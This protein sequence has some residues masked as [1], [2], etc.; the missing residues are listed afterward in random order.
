M[1]DHYIVLIR[2]SQYTSNIHRIVPNST[3]AAVADQLRK[4]LKHTKTELRKVKQELDDSTTQLSSKKAGGTD[5]AK[6]ALLNVEHTRLQSKCV[7]PPFLHAF[8]VVDFGMFFSRLHCKRSLF[9]LLHSHDDARVVCCVWMIITRSQ[10]GAFF[11]SPKQRYCHALFTATTATTI[12][13]I[14]T[15]DRVGTRASAATQRT[16]KA[17]WASYARNVTRWQLN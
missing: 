3:Q 11:I 10:F 2:T 13:I 7:L 14:T 5:D 8:V 16:T 15:C 6:L 4:E 1:A 12:I 17:T 9:F